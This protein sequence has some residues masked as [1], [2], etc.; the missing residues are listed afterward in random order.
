MDFRTRLDGWK[1]VFGIEDDA[2]SVLTS[3]ISSSDSPSILAQSP[4]YQHPTSYLC[5]RQP[6]LAQPSCSKVTHG[7]QTPRWTYVDSRACAQSLPGQE[8]SNGDHWKTNKDYAQQSVIPS[9]MATV[10][11]S[12]LRLEE[13]QVFPVTD[14]NALGNP[15]ENPLGLLQGSHGSGSAM[16]PFDLDQTLGH[17]VCNAGS[18]DIIS[19]LGEEPLN[20][21]GFT[22]RD[23]EMNFMFNGAESPITTPASPEF[24]ETNFPQLPV[25]AAVLHLQRGVHSQDV[26]IRCK[27]LSIKV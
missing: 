26:C 5:D 7:D 18:E 22:Q 1:K 20:Q 19:Y 16:S 15:F 3:L 6:S 8:D 13:S 23:T 14:A 27:A 25:E 24:S 11:P 4:S 12:Q 9:T 17:A 10:E 21:V 2:F